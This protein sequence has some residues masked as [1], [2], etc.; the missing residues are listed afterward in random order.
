MLV[1]LHGKI[2]HWKV[3]MVWFPFTFFSYV[4][5]SFSSEILP[6]NFTLSAEQVFLLIRLLKSQ[7]T[8]IRSLNDLF[9][10]DSEPKKFTGNQLCPLQV[11]MSAAKDYHFSKSLQKFEMIF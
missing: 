1:T 10:P 5:T 9:L 4:R 7:A 8:Q 2:L 11:V 3:N 6:S